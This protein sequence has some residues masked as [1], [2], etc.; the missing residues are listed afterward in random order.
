M[1]ES[2]MGKQCALEMTDIMS[3]GGHKKMFYKKASNEEPVEEDKKLSSL[4]DVVALFT[5]IS[6]ELDNLGLERTA[7]SVLN[8]I[9]GIVSEAYHVSSEEDSP[10]EEEE[11]EGE[12]E[13]E[14]P[15]P[16]EL[17]KKEKEE[18]GAAPDRKNQLTKMASEWSDAPPKKSML[19]D[20]ELEE[21][22]QAIGELDEWIE[23]NAQP[24]EGVSMEEAESDALGSIL[25]EEE[26]YEEELEPE[27]KTLPGAALKSEKSEVEPEK[28]EDREVGTDLDIKKLVEELQES[29]KEEQEYEEL[30]E[31]LMDVPKPEETEDES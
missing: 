23:K 7:E 21:V 30:I 15:A 14:S 19:T 17:S 22:R 8:V 13:S 28:P 12:E 24:E 20:S 3:G 6:I 10:K 18:K 4:D 16:W 27:S 1:F 9:S 11:E 26:A 2:K 25:E 5:K 31:G 29:T